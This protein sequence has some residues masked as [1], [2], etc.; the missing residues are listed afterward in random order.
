MVTQGQRPLW[1]EIEDKI[2][3]HTKQG[4]NEAEQESVIQKIAADAGIDPGN[5]A[6]F[7]NGYTLHCKRVS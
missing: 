6:I 2:L 5:L 4:L 7:I 1:L 3:E